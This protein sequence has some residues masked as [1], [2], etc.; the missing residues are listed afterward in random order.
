MHI[1]M[2]INSACPGFDILPSLI[3]SWFGWLQTQSVGPW[4]TAKPNCGLV[5][6]A[7]TQDSQGLAHYKAQLCMGLVSAILS[8]P[9]VWHTT[10]PLCGWAWHIAKPLIEASSFPWTCLGEEDYKGFL[11]H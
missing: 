9:R 4:H 6:L 2:G 8:V 7:Q 3:A 11:A 1:L 10:N 5:W